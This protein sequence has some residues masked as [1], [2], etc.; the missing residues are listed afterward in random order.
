MEEKLGEEKD[1]KGERERERERE[2][3]FWSVPQ[4]QSF[5]TANHKK[6]K[7]RKKTRKRTF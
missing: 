7:I 2:N 3:I 5:I 6:V 4:H 1:G